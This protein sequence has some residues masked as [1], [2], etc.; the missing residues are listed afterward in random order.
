MGVRRGIWIVCFL[1]LLGSVARAEMPAGEYAVTVGGDAGLV[2]PSGDL[3]TCESTPDGDLCIT[4]SV[5]TDASGIVTGNAV[6]TLDG[7][8]VSM[9]LNLLL[10]GQVGGSTVKPKTVLHFSAQGSATDGLLVLDIL[11][12]GKMKCGLDDT[13]PDQLFC[14]GRMKLC[15]YID[16]DKLDCAGLP[17]GTSV[18]FTRT[19]FDLQLDLATGEKNVVT[20][21][22]QVLIDAAPAFAYSAKGKYK[23]TTDATNLKLTSVDPE[24]KTKIALKQAVLEAGSASAGVVTFKI[25]GQKGK[26]TL[27]TP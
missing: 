15:A 16:G 27:P 18:G 3:E 13:M 9:D 23:P 6:L 19:P 4:S 2:L 11:G 22:A 21:D 24:A 8:G 25:A 5:D 7:S 12:S 10:D 17:F 20:G 26:A 1:G 14:K